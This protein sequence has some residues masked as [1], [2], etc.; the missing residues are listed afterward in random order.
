MTFWKSPSFKALQD[1]WYQRLADEGFR[2]QEV[3]VKGEMQLKW[4]AQRAYMR[5]KPLCRE[6]REAYFRL[7]AQK[8]Q[9]NGFRSEI[10]RLILMRYA[11]GAKI[12]L[13]IEELKAIGK[14]RCR[15]SVTFIIR[16]YEMEWGLKEYTP[17]QL[18][19]REAS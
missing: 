16:R 4:D 6:M 17:K 1:A 5:M 11:E 10:D 2:D 8:V 15:N 12:K 3:L 19:R 14:T 7:L 13:I 18:N 9:E